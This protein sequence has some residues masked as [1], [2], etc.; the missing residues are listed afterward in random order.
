MADTHTEVGYMDMTAG[1]LG[2]AEARV[3]ILLAPDASEAEQFAA[4][5]LA[6]A[7]E[8]ITARRI[9]IVNRYEANRSRWTWLVIGDVALSGAPRRR[10]EALAEGEVLIEQAGGD[11]VRFCGGGSA[12]ALYAVYQ[13]L[14][15]LGCRHY[16][17]DEAFYPSLQR[18]VVPVGL[19]IAPSFEHREM[20][21]EPACT[22]GDWACRNRLNGSM[23]P[24]TERHGGRRGIDPYTHSFYTFVPPKEYAA[25]HPEYFSLRRGQGRVTSGAQICLSNPDVIGL[26]VDFALAQMSKPDVRIVALSHMDCDNPCQCDACAAKDARAGASSGSL[27]EFINSVAERTSAHYPDKCV[28][29][30]AYT[31]TQTPPSGLTVHDNA[32]IRLCH[33]EP[34]CDAHGLDQ[35]KRNERYVECL[36][37]WRKIAKRVYVWH[38]ATNFLHNLGFHPNF[39]ALANDVRFYRDAGV[40]G[41]FLQGQP[42]HGVS[43]GHLHAFVQS[44]VMWDAGRDY[45]REVE[46]FLG[47]YYGPAADAMLKLIDVLHENVRAGKHLHLYTHPAT[48]SFTPHQLD[49][50]DRCVERAADAAADDAKFARRIEYVKL[51]RDYTRLVSAP[52]IARSSQG[53]RV[54]AVPNAPSLLKRCEQ[55]M[56]S[57][58]VTHIHE[59]PHA[60]QD[61]RE[62]LG[63]STQTRDL[64]VA[65][66]ENEHLRIEVVSELAGMVWTMLDKRT[67]RDVC[68]KPAPHMLRYPFIGG[69]VEGCTRDGFGAGFTEAYE[70]EPTDE[71]DSIVITGKFSNG[72]SARRV[73]TVASDRPALRIASTY[74]NESDSP[75]ELMPNC[76]FVITL[77]RLDDV[78]FFRHDAEKKVI[79]A[80]ASFPAGGTVSAAQWV[81]QSGDQ[82]PVGQWGCF[83][84]SLGLG[85]LQTFR[86]GEVSQCNSNAYA[87]DQ[88]I[89]LE[90]LGVRREVEP[91][92]Q[93]DFHHSYETIHAWPT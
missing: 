63:W 18:I 21:W 62:Y 60:H 44:R 43:F 84:D 29:T 50:A 76:E 16:A 68:C 61:L 22:D 38:Y 9:K 19:R 72:V 24:L 93:L 78:R 57:L 79:D 25:S 7:L 91:G 83:N 28:M 56:A 17:P 46:D 39:D 33:M 41:V 51:W 31:Y 3:S 64:A 71:A 69:Y 65:A 15:E 10:E 5:E 37:G 87:A 92:G 34:S 36:H 73:L 30:I 70:V 81:V 74:R 89:M 20:L 2:D 45:F 42:K 47:A 85:L 53:V 6:D 40:S 35:C 66:I 67:G 77:G 52:P 23:Q 32:I 82:L 12:G 1:F 13:W 80:R 14:E 26:A 8:K 49:E 4:Q 86:P 11:A 27:V 59:F 55:S 90:T 88:R 58:G 48:G 54:Q 75:L